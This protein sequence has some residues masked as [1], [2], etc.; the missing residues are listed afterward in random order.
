MPRQ[1][2]GEDPDLLLERI[3]RIENSVFRLKAL[4]E[5]L[6]S[7]DM[8]EQLRLEVLAAELRARYQ[9]AVE[10]RYGS[11]EASADGE[12]KALPA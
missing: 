1:N 6:P 5:N 11:C 3:I 4:S 2:H 7:W 12:G 9:L 8:S 10:A